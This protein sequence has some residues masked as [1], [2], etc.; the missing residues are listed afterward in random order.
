MKNSDLMEEEAIADRLPPKE[1]KQLITE[2]NEKY[3][4]DKAVHR[5]EDN[6]RSQE[7]LHTGKE[8]TPFC[9]MHSEMIVIDI[10][11][12]VQFIRS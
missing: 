1:R 8:V 12:I 11:Y 9:T 3:S 2:D 10:A 6:Y 4:N 7:F 5:N